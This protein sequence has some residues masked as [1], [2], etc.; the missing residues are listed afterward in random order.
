MTNPKCIVTCAKKF[1]IPYTTLYTWIKR[2]RLKSETYMKKEKKTWTPMEKFQL[3]LQAQTL[4][5]KNLGGFLRENGIYEATL[6]QWK[7]ECLESL[8]QSQNTTRREKKRLEKKIKKLEREVSRKDK[9]LAESTA[10]LV[11]S[12]KFQA[13]WEDEGEDT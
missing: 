4:N 13:L 7:T 8:G 10:L 11:L 1:N 6:K 5:D 2:E 9:A 12:K 3:I